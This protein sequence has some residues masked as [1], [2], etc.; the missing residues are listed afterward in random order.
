[1]NQLNEL[2]DKK[3]LLNIKRTAKKLSFFHLWIIADQKFPID[4][5]Y[6]PLFKAVA[7]SNES[8]M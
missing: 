7:K 1:M 3:I 6:A 5:I 4:I 2:K 8:F